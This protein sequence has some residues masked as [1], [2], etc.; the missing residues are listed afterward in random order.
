MYGLVGFVFV[1]VGGF[2]E[3][4]E[5]LA[6]GGGGGFYFK[7]CFILRTYPLFS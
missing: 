5:K 2:K 4:K 1:V 6:R 7:D 3:Q